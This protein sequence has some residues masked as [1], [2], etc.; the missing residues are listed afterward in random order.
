[1]LHGVGISAVNALSEKM[2]TQVFRDGKQVQMEFSKG[3]PKS[4]LIVV[5]D[6]DIHGTLQT[7]LPDKTI[8]SETDFSFKTI[9]DHL[10]QQAYLTKSLNI[11]CIDERKDPETEFNFYFEGGIS[12]FVR[13]LTSTKPI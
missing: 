10:R 8:F 13:S 7:F 11:K 9:I 6:T 5:G 1:G 3:I 4:K 2:V 12:S